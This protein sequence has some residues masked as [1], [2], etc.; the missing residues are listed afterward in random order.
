MGRKY[1]STIVPTRFLCTVGHLIA[2][3]MI[4]Y[5]KA[6]NIQAGLSID[7]T[8]TQYNT[9]NTS[10]NW[11]IGLHFF[12]FTIEFLGLF[13]GISLYSPAIHIFDIFAHFFGALILSWSIID[14]WHYDYIW[15]VWGF[16]SLIPALLETLLFSNQICFKKSQY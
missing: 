4:S 15:I 9:A 16:F 5:T 6:A 12:C 10:V 8:T 14:S 2:I 13:T 1:L 3:W 7:Y 11:A